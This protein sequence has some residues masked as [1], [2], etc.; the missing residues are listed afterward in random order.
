M[1]NRCGTISRYQSTI[2]FDHR[3]GSDLLC[4]SYPRSFF[5]HTCVSCRST[6]LSYSHEDNVALQNDTSQWSLL[7]G[8]VLYAE[9][10]V[11]TYE[12]TNPTKN[13]A[14]TSLPRTRKGS[15][16]ST[17][18]K[19]PTCS[20]KVHPSPTG[21]KGTSSSPPQALCTSPVVGR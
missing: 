17:A 15:A 21:P 11:G 10:I 6:R 12:N 13:S 4:F 19:Y 2:I 18:P 1:R 3:I 16:S 20:E 5:Q 7:S 14:T 9:S 8:P